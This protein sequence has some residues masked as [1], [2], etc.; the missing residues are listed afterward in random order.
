MT[1]A[2]IEA[3]LKAGRDEQA[4]L[5]GRIKE[6]QD[7]TDMLRLCLLLDIDAELLRR[8]KDTSETFGDFVGKIRDGFESTVYEELIDAVESLEN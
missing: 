3:L 4:N 7:Y 1:K 5:V 2:K 6:R 8:T